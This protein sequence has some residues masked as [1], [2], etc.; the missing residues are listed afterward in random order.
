MIK[1]KKS[2]KVFFIFGGT[3]IFLLIGLYIVGVIIV[4]KPLISEKE[5][6]LNYSAKIIWEIVVNNNDYEWRTGVKN[7]EIIDNNNW[8]E[9]YDEKG[10]SFTKFTLEYKE[11]FALYGFRMENRNFF[12]NWIGKFIEINENTTKCIFEET[13]YIKNPIIGVIAKLFWNLEKLQ[14]QYFEDLKKKL[15]K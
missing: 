4:K 5:I 12:G 6:I 15:E 7:I 9:Y 2:L 10:K 13:I 1:M 14:I 8:I 3:V 11:E